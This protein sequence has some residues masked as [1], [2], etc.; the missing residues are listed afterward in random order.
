MCFSC[1]NFR[2]PVAE[3]N[4]GTAIAT[5]HRKQRSVTD[6]TGGFNLHALQPIDDACFITSLSTELIYHIIDFVPPESHLDFACTCKRLAECSSKVLKRHQE[7]YSR[8]RVS[9]DI[10]PTTIPTLLRSVFARAD[11]ILAWH[12]RSLEIWYDRT[13]WLDWKPLDFDQ[14]LHGEDM[15]LDSV[16]WQ[17][18]DDEL[19]EYLGDIENQFDALVDSGDE[20]ARTDAREQFE[21]GVD[22]FLKML[23]I[24]Y[25]PRLQD[26]KFITQEHR[27]KSTLGWLRRI[28]QG[29][30]LCGSHWPPGL[31][32]IHE[33]A[34]GVESDTWM[35]QEQPEG[36]DPVNRSMETFSTLLRLPRIQ[37]MY[38]ND[39]RHEGWNDDTEYDSRTLMPPRSSTVKHIFLDDCSDIPYR[40]RCALFQA[41][42]ALETFTLRAGDY[43][44]RMDDADAL[45]SGICSVQ[46]KSLHTLMFYGPYTLAQIH[47]YRCC[48]YR[49]EELDTADNLKTVAIHVSDVELDSCYHLADETN[50]QEDKMAYEEQRRWFVKW[51][52]QTAF[53]N[54]IERL[55]FWGEPSDCYLGQLKRGDFL[56]WLEDALIAAIESRRWVNKNDGDNGEEDADADRKVHYPNLKAV[57]LEDIESVQAFPYRDQKP[58]RTKE[59]RF[60]RL[61]EVGKIAGVDVHTL[62]NRMPAAYLHSFP[63]APDKYDL[64]SGPWWERRDEVEDWVFDAYKGRRVP[65]GCGK[66]GKCETCLR[67]YSEELWM[68]LNGDESAVRRSKRLQ[69]CDMM[70]TWGTNV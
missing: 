37:S 66:C 31:S 64:R 2:S 42:Q 4:L 30:I 16:L 44:D 15:D 8:Y 21:D 5:M 47:G 56:T 61:I 12:V 27:D 69:A 62:T 68:K 34:V 35:S 49:N 57:Y 59:M 60:R 25:C 53:P 9:S 22:G 6:D 38:Y 20:D 39:I 70:D 63:K 55:I 10:L 52:C 1:F 45:V 14:Q 48:V 43:G 3:T 29:C 23:L 51:F 13:S 7:A 19:S 17:W 11:P 40:F 58:P 33:V 24:A 41:P 32:N 67:E 36:Q 50:Q 28:I 46:S 26:V 65:P 54:T 18:G